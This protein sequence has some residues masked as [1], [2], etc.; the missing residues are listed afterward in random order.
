MLFLYLGVIALQQAYDNK[1]MANKA[2]AVL[3]L[4]GSFNLVIIKMSVVWWNTLHQPSS[5]TKGAIDMSM[6]IPLLVNMF[7]VYL[8]FIGLLL[9]WTRIEI[10]EQESRSSWVKV[11]ISQNTDEK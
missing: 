2:S 9:M 3:A 8:L 6:L 5:I 4:V 10:L 7:G 1:E 11:L